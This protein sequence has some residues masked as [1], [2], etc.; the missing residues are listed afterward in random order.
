MW[1][2]DYKVL[3]K[4]KRFE[5]FTR[6]SKREFLAL[7][8]IILVAVTTSFCK[9]AAASSRRNISHVV[10]L[11]IGI[12]IAI[13]FSIEYAL[14]CFMH[15]TKTN[16]FN[17]LFLTSGLLVSDIGLVVM[18][19]KDSVGPSFLVI[20]IQTILIVLGLNLLLDLIIQNGH[21]EFKL[22]QYF[23]LILL[24]LNCVSSI[25]YV[26]S[27]SRRPVEI[28]AI[29][30]S[31]VIF[32]IASIYIWFMYYRASSQV[33]M[34]MSATEKAYSMSLMAAL[35]IV[36]FTGIILYNLALIYPK[37]LNIQTMSILMMNLN[38]ICVYVVLLWDWLNDRLHSMKLQVTSKE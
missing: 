3:M 6:Y 10:P 36:Y 1:V 11:L 20:Q 17:L 14:D 38:W 27:Q 2:V 19:C 30:L 33:S 7:L 18:W 25:G 34:N 9:S 16:R 29:V 24:L 5:T 15:P 12:F 32:I 23:F 13:D 21:K 37:T 4:S 22:R 26:S 8:V 28:V 35:C 31:A